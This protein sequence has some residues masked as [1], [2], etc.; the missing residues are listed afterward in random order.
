MIGAEVA[1]ADDGFDNLGRVTSLAYYSQDTTTLAAYGLPVR[2]RRQLTKEQ[3]DRVASGGCPPE[4][5]RSSC[6][7]LLR[8]P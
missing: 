3:Q 7:P 5:T 1:T 8:S 2:C 6:V 4:A